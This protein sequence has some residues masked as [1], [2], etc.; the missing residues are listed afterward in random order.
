MLSKYLLSYLLTATRGGMTRGKILESLRKKPQN[1]HQLSKSLNLDYKTIQHHIDVL[2]DNGVISAV[3]KG[4]YGAL[5]HWSIDMEE[6][7][8]LFREMVNE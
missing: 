4:S 1:M 2:I 8:K 7:V 5:Y 3:K 6:N